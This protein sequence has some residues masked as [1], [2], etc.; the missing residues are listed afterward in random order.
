M[1]KKTD[2]TTRLNIQAFWLLSTAIAFGISI[3]FGAKIFFGWLAFLGVISICCVAMTFAAVR[4]SRNEKYWMSPKQLKQFTEIFDK[5]LATIPI[6]GLFPKFWPVR[7]LSEELVQ[8]ERKA[9]ERK[10]VA[11]YSR[12]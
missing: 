6:L 12:G 7:K 1:R 10:M 8:R 2:T 3:P 5:Y 11:Y 4:A 9:W